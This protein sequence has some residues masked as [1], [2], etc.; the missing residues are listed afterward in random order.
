MS[1]KVFPTVPELI[2]ALVSVL[3]NASNPLTNDEITKEVIAYLGLPLET[4]ELIHSGGRTEL[5]YR[6]AWARTKASKQ[7]LIRHAAPATWA[8][9]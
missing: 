1:Q 5:D 3:G 7:G 9:I 4:T 8:I 2:D 6:L